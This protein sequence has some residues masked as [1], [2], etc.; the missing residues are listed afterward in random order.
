MN[1]IYGQHENENRSSGTNKKTES[2]S[3]DIGT[4]VTKFVGIKEPKT[5]SFFGYWQKNIE[6]TPDLY[7]LA[8]DRERIFGHGIDFGSTEDPIVR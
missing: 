4:V 3:D 6:V 8:M 2:A 5:I 1:S 7:N